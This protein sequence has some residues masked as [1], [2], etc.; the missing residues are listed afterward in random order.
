[1]SYNKPLRRTLPK[2]FVR[3]NEEGVKSFIEKRPAQFKATMRDDAPNVWP[4]YSKVD[5]GPDPDKE[6]R[7][8][9][10]LE[11]MKKEKSKL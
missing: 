4:W 11:R 8:L 1:M 5:I 9:A 7:E 6:G 2:L 10:R 3:D